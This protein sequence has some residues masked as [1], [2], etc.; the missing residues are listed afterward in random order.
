MYPRVQAATRR[1]RGKYTPDANVVFID[2]TLPGNCRTL[3]RFV[4]FNLSAHD[5]FP[6]RVANISKGGKRK[7]KDA[8]PKKES[9]RNKN[10][11]K[12]NF[13]REVRLDVNRWRKIARTKI[14]ARKAYVHRRLYY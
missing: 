9:E 1:E 5:R 2:E 10:K 14:Y 8:G 4:F 7:Q 3:N 12:R 11:G 6:Y 13:H